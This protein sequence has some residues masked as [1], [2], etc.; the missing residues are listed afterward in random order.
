MNHR[1]NRN[2]FISVVIPV[3]LGLILL[4]TISGCVNEEKKDNGTIV[5]QETPSK[6]TPKGVSSST[7]S[8]LE[9]YDIKKLISMSDNIIIGDVSEVLPSMWNTPDG[10]RAPNDNREDLFIYT[11]AK[12]KIGESLKGSLDTDTVVVRVLGGSVEPYGQYSEDQP[13]YKTNEKVLVFLKKDSNPRTQDVGIGH[14]TTTGLI[15]GK[16]SISQNNQVIIGDEKMSLD[17][18][19]NKITESG[20]VSQ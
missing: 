14:M 1:K 19:K 9:K 13:S 10:K 11:D 6:D 8:M 5:P 12:I 7:G 20:K 15:Q 18:V 16:I 3:I 17:D 4:I 2:I